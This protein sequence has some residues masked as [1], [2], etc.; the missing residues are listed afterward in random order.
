MTDRSAFG[1]GTTRHTDP[2]VTRVLFLLRRNAVLAFGIGLAVLLVGAALLG[3]GALAILGWTLL[4]VDVV[5]T[6]AWIAVRM[7]A[8]THRPS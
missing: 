1:G 2:T 8:R 3:G 4:L 6:I 7:R 5:G